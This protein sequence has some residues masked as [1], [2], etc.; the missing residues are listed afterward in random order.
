LRAIDSAI[1]S[2]AQEAGFEISGVAALCSLLKKPLSEFDPR[3]VFALDAAYVA[4]LVERFDLDFDAR[5]MAVE[6]HPWHPN[7][8]LPYQVHT[9][10]EWALMLRGIK[11][12]AVFVDEHPSPHGLH[13]IPE[14]EFEPHVAAG[15]I[16]KREEVV[17]PTKGAPVVRG[18]RIGMRRVL[19]ALPDEAWRID[20]CF[21]LWRTAEKSGW[22]E[23]FE[24]MEGSLLE[25]EDWQND[26]YIE[27]R[28]RR[29]AIGR[30]PSNA[31]PA[32]SVFDTDPNPPKKL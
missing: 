32:L 12:P 15:R 25:Y 14:P 7:D 26:V 17:P 27:R 9:G 2:I 6:L 13:V 16:V 21:L 18:Q 30:Q 20:A 10:R 24:R 1:A 19:Y 22:N 11:P 3:A 23:G 8:D 31:S 29:D 4:A 28:Y 5:A